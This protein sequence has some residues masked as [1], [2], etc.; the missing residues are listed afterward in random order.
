MPVQYTLDMKYISNSEADTVK[1][2]EDLGTDLS[3][4]EVIFLRG[5]LGAGKSVFARALIRF[6]CGDKTLEV[7]SPTFTLVQTYEWPKG[8]ILHFDLYRL[9]DPEEIYNLGWEDALGNT[10][11][12]VEWPERLGGHIPLKYFEVFLETDTENL[13]SRSINVKKHG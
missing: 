1:V 13:Y 9:E 6:L 2:A 3:G 5:D 7:P 4:T 8:E 12:L 11:M 10:L